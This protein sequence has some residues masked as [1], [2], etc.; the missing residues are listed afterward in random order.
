[1]NEVS[2]DSLPFAGEKV[3]KS[4]EQKID[5]VIAHRGLEIAI[6]ACHSNSYSSF[7]AVYP[8]EDNRVEVRRKILTYI[9]SNP[10]YWN[11]IL[12]CAKTGMWSIFTDILYSHAN[13]LHNWVRSLTNSL[14]AFSKAVKPP[15]SINDSYLEYIVQSHSE[16]I[17]NHEILIRFIR[18]VSEVANDETNKLNGSARNFINLHF[19]HGDQNAA[20]HRLMRTLVLYTKYIGVGRT[21][22]RLLKINKVARGT[23]FNDSYKGL[24]L[25]T[26]NPAGM[27]LSTGS[28]KKASFIGNSFNADSRHYLYRLQLKFLASD[29]Y[30]TKVPSMGPNIS[31]PAG[32]KSKNLKMQVFTCIKVPRLKRRTSAQYT[33]TLIR[34]YGDLLGAH[35]A[36]KYGLSVGLSVQQNAS[37][38][39]LSDR[40][41]RISVTN[42]F[43]R[44]LG[45]TSRGVVETDTLKTLSY[46]QLGNVPY[47]VFKKNGAIKE[48]YETKVFIPLTLEVTIPESIL[49][50]RN[51]V[52]DQEALGSG[53]KEISSELETLQK[54]RSFAGHMLS[55]DGYDYA[56]LPERAIGEIFAPFL[57]SEESQMFSPSM[58]RRRRGRNYHQSDAS[59]GDG[60]ITSPIL[61]TVDCFDP[62]TSI[63]SIL[64]TEAILLASDDITTV[65]STLS[66]RII[67][68]GLK[69]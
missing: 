6:Q 64:I 37:I 63:P 22:E 66:R 53:I 20:Q 49:D 5:E 19:I 21:V 18:F 10:G 59:Y 1:M 67:R 32:G 15:V 29:A 12:G 11:L 45:I 51:L 28:G 4:F 17:A 24:F 58:S 43:R 3:E 36:N 61:H 44:T 8:D 2:V 56:T 31:R 54:Q 33:S 35:F 69:K 7:R 34:R 13:D 55:R 52:V 42:S 26:P 62:T 23:I 57:I 41:T 39:D 9:L 65:L 60:V 50:V 27:N 30:A 68:G 14:M 40:E 47:V 16:A 25:L 46:Q 38:T 48:K